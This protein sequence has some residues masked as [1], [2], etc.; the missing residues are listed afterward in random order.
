[1]KH[2]SRRKSAKRKYKRLLAA[3]TGAAIVSSALLPGLPITTAYAAENPLVAAPAPTVEESKTPAPVKE[4][5]NKEQ[6]NK[7]RPN[8]EQPD[9]QQPN[10]EQPNKKGDKDRD[11]DRDRPTEQHKGSGSPVAVVK[12]AAATYGFDARRDNFTLQSSTSTEAVVLVHTTSGKTFKVLLNKTRDQ[13]R[14]TSVKTIVS[15]GIHSSDPVEVVRDNAGI[16]GF[17]KVKDRFSLL[18][19]AGN[20][21]VVQVKT[22]GQ[23]FK[24][25]LERSGAR[26]VITTIRGIGNSQYPATYRPA[27]LFGY[28]TSVTA[29]P[30]VP[31]GER[32]LYLNSNYTD[33]SWRE[34]GY[35]ANMK[36]GVLLAKPDPANPLGIPD[37]IIEKAADIDFGRQLVLYAHI[38]SVA[39]QGYGIAI[40]RV[41]QTGNDLTVSVRT[42]SPSD[43]RMWFPS[44][45]N[46]MI[47]LDRLSLNFNK[48]IQIKFID[49]NGTVLNNY[50]L[51]TR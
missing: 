43:N 44:V 11:R 32:I 13:W 25:D 16:F 21:A 8:K 7:E 17:D 35:P 27:S 22:S 15:G 18:S 31:V 48:P 1:M 34:S 42:K 50:T 5:P 47:P 19:V 49:Q 41:V 36:L 33:W 3:L 26:W 6:P 12:A 24:V 46:E 45:T 23:T 28:R 14:I 2:T 51:H 29:V 37:A 4:Q 39:D 10:K 9:K 40:E 20:K 38:G 30:V